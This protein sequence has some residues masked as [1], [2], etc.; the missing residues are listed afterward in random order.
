MI[1]MMMMMMM[2]GSCRS[3]RLAC[4]HHTPIVLLD[5]KAA[6]PSK[7]PC[8]FIALQAYHVGSPIVILSLHRVSLSGLLMLFASISNLHLALCYCSLLVVVFCAPDYC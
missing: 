5:E 4:T 3:L 2:A 1:V 8:F 6:L 7:I